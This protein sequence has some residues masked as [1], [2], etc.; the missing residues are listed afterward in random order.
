M[1]TIAIDDLENLGP[2]DLRV[3]D[4]H[5]ASLICHY[6]DDLYLGLI[7]IEGKIRQDESDEYVFIRNSSPKVQSIPAITGGSLVIY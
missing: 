7:M 1:F 3:F 6:K 4:G 5:I 2:Y